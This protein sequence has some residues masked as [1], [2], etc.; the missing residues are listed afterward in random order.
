MGR[1]VLIVDDEVLETAASLL[2]ELGYVV[3]TASN[4]TEALDSL[5]ND[6]HIEILIADIN[7]PNL[8]GRK[9]AFRAKQMRPELKVLLLS[10]S[11]NDGYGFPLIRKPFLQADLT[12]AMQET[13][14]LC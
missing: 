7:M 9:L 8:D 13:T 6:P 12:R 4:G 10:G 3:Q 11:E 5:G 2:E 14:G 1:K